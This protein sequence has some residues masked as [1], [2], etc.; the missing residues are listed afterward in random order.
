MKPEILKLWLWI[1]SIIPVSQIEA[2]QASVYFNGGFHSI[3]SRSFNTFGSNF[4]NLYSARLAKTIDP[5]ML[6]FDL[7]VGANY[8]LEN[9]WLFGGE[10]FAGFGEASAKFIDSSELNFKARYDVGTAYA[11]FTP[12]PYDEILY[13]YPFAGFSA[14]RNQMSATNSLADSAVAVIPDGNYSAFTF[15][16]ITGLHVAFGKDN[17]KTLVRVSYMLPL[18]SSRLETE[19]DSAIAT[20]QLLYNQNTSTYKGDYLRSDWRDLSI[21]V[22]LAVNFGI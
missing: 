10:Y 16:F 9:G 4:N 17:V 18:I 15:K 1:F 19:S 7:G 5:K 21:N 8:A 20:D 12:G 6:N 13:L 14:G 11:G 22:G 2:Q 3:T